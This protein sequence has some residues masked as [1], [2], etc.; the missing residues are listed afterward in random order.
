MLAK[1]KQLYQHLLVQMVRS[2]ISLKQG[3]EFF[4]SQ[5][6][7]I[8]GLSL[9]NGENRH[10]ESFVTLYESILRLNQGSISKKKKLK[11]LSILK[12]YSATKYEKKTLVHS[13]IS[14]IMI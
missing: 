9:V 6:S 1:V 5:E 8:L 4:F 12:Y 2:L 10:R 11:Q 13:Y 14:F 7:K 3:I